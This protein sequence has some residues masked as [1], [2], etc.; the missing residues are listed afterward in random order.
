MPIA[1]MPDALLAWYINAAGAGRRGTRRGTC[2]SSAS[3]HAARS[4]RRS[5]PHERTGRRA[6][7]GT[8]RRGPPGR[9]QA[10]C[11]AT[12]RR[13]A[14]SRSEG[15]RATGF[16]HQ[17]RRLAQCAHRDLVRPRLLW[18]PHRVRRAI[19]PDD[20]GRRPQDAA[21][22]HARALPV[23]WHHGRGAGH[24][25]RTVRQRGLRVRLLGRARRATCSSPGASRTRASPATT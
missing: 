19:H 5:G 4:V 21:L 23:A 2:V 10:C 25:S 11:R 17:L 6:R 14:C 20:R 7:R 3:R 12:G 13:T 22:R 9:R 16:R 15:G 8:T 24:R 1:W 18:Q